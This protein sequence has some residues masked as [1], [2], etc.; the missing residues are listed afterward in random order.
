MASYS[1]YDIDVYMY[2][3][4]ESEFC[5]WKGKDCVF[6]WKHL[7]N[8]FSYEK[9]Y[10][11]TMRYQG[12]CMLP[13]FDLYIRHQDYDYYMFYEDDIAYLSKVNIFDKI[14]DTFEDKFDAIFQ[15]HRINNPTWIWTEQRFQNLSEIKQFTQYEGLCNIYIL[16]GKIINGL[17]KFIKKGYFAHHENLINSFVLNN[18]KPDRIKYIDDIFNIKCDW[19]PFDLSDC[20]NKYDI[21]HPVKQ[22]EDYVNLR[23]HNG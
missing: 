5:R 8:K 19:R 12:N 23:T 14:F 7:Q 17:I 1:K 21:V 4:E 6:G 11:K 18:Y 22:I 16:S 9:W 15:D 20:K 10:I 13:M 3:N 2:R